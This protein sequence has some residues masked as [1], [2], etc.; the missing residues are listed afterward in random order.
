[1][2]ET[3]KKTVYCPTCEKEVILNRKNFEHIYHEVL[4]F[5]VIMTIGL[6]FFIYLIL[7]YSKKKDRCPNCETQFDLQNLPDNNILEEGISN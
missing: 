6:G 2:I 1:M 4:C 7:K 5:L 3:G